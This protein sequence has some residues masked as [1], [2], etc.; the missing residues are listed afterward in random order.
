M[1]NNYIWI[2]T[3]KEMFHK[4]P[5]APDEVHYLRTLHRH[6]MKFKV[7]LEVFHNDRDIEFIMFKQYV[8]NSL[9]MIDQKL[10]PCKSCEMISDDI[11]NYIKETYPN[12][13]VMIEVSE[14]QENGSHKE[15]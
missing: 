13:K 6:M 8:V 7:W 1:E 11:Y 5:N 12:R 3:E 10:G 14:D 2:T 15:Y 4:Y 9:T